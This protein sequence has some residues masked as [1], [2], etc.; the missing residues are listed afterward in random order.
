MTSKNLIR[1]YRRASGMTQR[2][3]SAKAKIS[4]SMVAKLESGEQSNPSL[5]TLKKIATALDCDVSDLLSDEKL[6]VGENLR[7]E[8]RKAGLTQKAL[9]DLS[10]IPV[11]TIQGYES[12]KFTPKYSAIQKLCAAMGIPRSSL[13]PDIYDLSN[14]S[15]LELIQELERRE[16]ERL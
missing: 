3:L 7:I 13:L 10:G 15:T 6:T 4:Y 8:R 2:E 16:R 11:I 5:E 9:S 14:Y 12:G 1:Q